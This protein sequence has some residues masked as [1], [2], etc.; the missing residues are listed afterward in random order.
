MVGGTSGPVSRRSN[1]ESLTRPLLPVCDTTVFV[2]PLVSAQLRL[3]RVNYSA[4]YIL[5]DLESQARLAW[6]VYI[7]AFDFPVFQ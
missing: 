7:A 5:I 1:G 3:V 6:E 4:G 2:E